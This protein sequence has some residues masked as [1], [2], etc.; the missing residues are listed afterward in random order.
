M[1]HFRLKS[2][3]QWLFF[4]LLLHPNF[5]FSP[6]LCFFIFQSFL[7][8]LLTYFSLEMWVGGG[9]KSPQAFFLIS[10]LLFT[11]SFSKT[12]PI[13]F[14]FILFFAS[15]ST[16]SFSMNVSPFL[17]SFQ[18]KIKKKGVNSSKLGI[19]KLKDYSM[20]TFCAGWKAELFVE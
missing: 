11:F 16:S 1:W 13:V 3:P 10:S 20:N 4:A 5:Q 17:F 2:V 15:S 9:R 6:F 8:Q 7:L 19:L 12:V 18:K 14:L